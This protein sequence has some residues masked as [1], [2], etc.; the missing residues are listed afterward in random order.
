VTLA[1]AQTVGLQY[2]NDIRR[3]SIDGKRREFER[4]MLA[5]GIGWKVERRQVAPKGQLRRSPRVESFAVFA[6]GCSAQVRAYP[7]HG[8]LPALCVKHGGARG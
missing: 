3:G 5:L 8:S 4:F 6:C 7:L 2:R 1:K